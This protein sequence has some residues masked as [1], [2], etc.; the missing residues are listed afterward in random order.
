MKLRLFFYLSLLL[1]LSLAPPYSLAQSADPPK[2]AVVTGRVLNAT[3]GEPVKKAHMALSKAE[4]GDADEDASPSFVANTDADGHF[5]FDAVAPGNYRLA[6]Q[7]SGFAYT[8]YGALGANGP[9]TVLSLASEQKLDL[10]VKVVPLG[11]IAG[12]VLDADGDAVPDAIVSAIRSF[13]S[14]GKHEIERL[15]KI[16]TNDLGE[17]RLYDL[18]AGRYY[19]AAT[20]PSFM[21]AGAQP[22]D[23]DTG[24][25]YY[26]DATDL[27][28]ATPLELTAGGTLS[29]IDM[30]ATKARRVTIS[31]TILNPPAGNSVR[32]SLVPRDSTLPLKFI[33]QD[34]EYHDET[35]K[36]EIHGVAPGT[37]V[38]AASALGGTR[39][40]SARQQLAV[41]GAGVPDIALALSPGVDLDGHV[42]VEG[43]SVLDLSHIGVALQSRDEGGAEASPV[44][45]DGAFT[46]AGVVPNTYMLLVSGLPRNGYV[47]SVHVGEQEF[48]P[49]EIDLTRGAGGAL[50]ILVSTAA[51]Q[52][53]GVVVNDKQQPSGGAQVVLV[54]AQRQRGDLYKSTT[55][56]SAGGFSLEGITPGDYK[57]FA[58]QG[59]DTGAYQDPDFLKRIEDHGESVSLDENGSRS[60]QLKIIP[61]ALF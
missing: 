22:A 21:P 12:R 54:P 4:A 11:V 19:I 49:S 39:R 13:F 28:N 51:A 17:Y 57:L 55:T 60:I 6:V 46:I 45:R 24:L 34:A 15:G 53:S 35:G 40:F 42:R 8:Q 47:K 36:F 56:N 48:P 14:N 20:I 31:G 50:S 25:I 38:L 37:Y 30:M 41:T 5:S 3:T 26:Q 7:R 59:M 27:G 32:V 52:V 43:Q 61:A 29:N 16:K 18:P 23:E 58:W 2:K 44:S 9:G 33:R 1:L 10:T